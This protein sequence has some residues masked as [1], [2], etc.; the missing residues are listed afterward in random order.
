[1]YDPPKLSTSELIDYKTKITTESIHSHHNNFSLYDQN[2]LLMDFNLYQN[3]MQLSR[4]KATPE[5]I[6]SHYN[7]FRLYDQN[8]QLLDFDPY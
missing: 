8:T 1:M 5:S 4:T 6:R 2:A 7:N 3:I